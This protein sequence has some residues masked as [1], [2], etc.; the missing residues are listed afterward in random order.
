MRFLTAFLACVLSTAAVAQYTVEG[1]DTYAAPAYLVMTDASSDLLN[2]RGRFV[3]ELERLG[4][5]VVTEHQQGQMIRKEQVAVRTAEV[6]Q[7]AGPDGL[8]EKDLKDRLDT[9]GVGWSM[10]GKAQIDAYLAAGHVRTWE[11]ATPV[12]SF[13]NRKTDYYAWAEGTPVPASTLDAPGTFHY[14][15]FQYTYRESLSCGNTFAEI[16]GTIN[17]VSGGANRPLVTFDFKQPLLGGACPSTIIPELARRFKPDAST[18]AEADIA[19]QLK[20]DG[21]GLAAVGTLMIVAQPG[22]DC[23]GITS[24]DA[25]DLFALQLIPHFDI[26]DRSVQDLIFAEQQLGMTGL[27]READLV[28][29]GLQAGAQGILTVQGTCL[30][31]QSLWK[32]KLIDAQSSVLLLSAIGRDTTPQAVAESIANSL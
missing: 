11:V 8:S 29:A 19:I 28:E 10:W 5:R 15:S 13:L 12:T 14:F 16:H 32:A 6:L 27:I 21:A 20:D 17:D 30:A 7:A 22:T 31:E 25:L 2:A 23:A 9:R 24:T 26:V 3:A 1:M 18:T 4:F